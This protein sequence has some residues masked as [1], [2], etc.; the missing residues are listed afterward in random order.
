[1][2]APR[3]IAAS[4]GATDAGGAWSYTCAAPGAAGRLIIVQ[5]LQDGVTVQSVAVTAGTNITAID[6]TA[7]TWTRIP[8]DVQGGEWPVGT[9]V[10]LQHLW[11]GRSTG[12]S[13]PTISGTNST[14]EDLYIRAYEFADVSTGTTLA[15]ILDSYSTNNIGAGISAT[16]SDMSVTTTGPDRLALNF[17]VVTD[18]NA[19]AVFTGQT[20][21]TWV[22]VAEYA[23]PSGTDG[24]VQLQYSML[25]DAYLAPR[26]GSAAG[27]GGTGIPQLGQPFT[28]PNDMTVTRAGIYIYEPA[29]G[30]SVDVT[31]EIQTDSGGNPSGT[32]VGSGG[33]IPNASIPPS[34][35]LAPIEVSLS[36]TLTGGTTYWLVVRAA[37]TNGF[38]VAGTS[39]SPTLWQLVGSTWTESN[40]V[41][42]GFVATASAAGTI[43]GGTASITDSDAWG[44]VGFALIGATT[45]EPSVAAPYRRPYLQ[46]LAH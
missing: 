40:A 35:P 10:G 4:T 2:A 8:G 32:V 38:L 27:V 26:G 42:S 46:L 31:V 34:S 22:E 14:S 43:D 28:P 19:I 21:G 39:G 17:V 6:G 9:G 37:G 30:E 25:G 18:D 16:A 44:V 12:T 45:E 5:A 3:F 29:A 13:A 33:T 36:A 15:A 23:E 11:V 24:A 7:N 41:L 20:G 1:M